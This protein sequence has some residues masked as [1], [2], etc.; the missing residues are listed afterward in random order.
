MTLAASCYKDGTDFIDKAQ[1]VTI[2]PVAADFDA[3]GT[4][5]GSECFTSTVFISEGNS[6][7]SDSWTAEVDKDW[8]RVE[9]TT[10][11]Y[12]YTDDNGKVY[13]YPED[14]INIFVDANKA[15][16]RYFNLTI[17]T[18]SGYKEVIPF[19]QKGALA[20]AEVKSETTELSFL[21]KG[22]TKVVEYTSNMGNKYEYKAV[23]E[24]ETKEWISFVDKGVGKVEV[25]A[26]PWSDKE[27]SRK[28][29]VQI[30]VGTDAT[31]KAVLE[32]PV[33]QNANYD[34]FYMYGGAVD[35]K[36]IDASIEME[37]R[38]PT[39]YFCEAYVTSTKDGKN[40]ILINK[41]GRTLAYPCYALAANGSIVELANA[42]AEVPQGP[43]IDINGM[44][45]IT[46]IWNDM[47]WTM[48]NVQVANAMPLDEL[49]NYPTKAYA[50]PSGETKT[51]MT[52]CLHWNGGSGVGAMKLGSM[53]ASAS[54]PAND[55]FGNVYPSD[56]SSAQTFDC[57]ESGGQVKGEEAISN[58]YG[59]I[60][61]WDEV[62]LG[63]PMA[64][65]SVSFSNTAWPE[66][67]CEG[68]TF[69]DAVGREFTMPAGI[70]GFTGDDAAV[71]KATPTVYMQI[72]GICPYGWHVANL[73]DWRD[74][75][76]A[77]LK[78]CGKE[79]D[80]KGYATLTAG[81]ADV[82]ATLKGAEGWSAGTPA[83]NAY[84]DDFGF[85][86]YPLGRRLYK[87]GYANLGI[88][89]EIWVCHPGAK[90]DIDCITGE[91]V[92]KVWRLA[93]TTYNGTTKLN[94]T[95]DTGNATA[96]IRCVKNYK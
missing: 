15:Y 67:Y 76:Y 12:S 4:V 36:A 40:Q 79:G 10:V 89:S 83:R 9:K 60:Y 43:A 21:A 53:V 61:A 7:S 33:T 73:Q 35:G 8:A 41:N 88:N 47:T 27:N 24:G 64:G 5:D 56:R 82:A 57:T 86:I 90:G 3:D 93:A 13:D 30:I 37:R 94:G 48:S 62:L 68:K 65:M 42:S 23:Y 66:K 25:V 28:A 72:Q 52:T 71:E 75:F 58:K 18:E 59:R 14:G 17:T 1:R 51:W 6:K 29:K 80:Y 78:A 96:P 46:V 49:A 34:Y 26:A 81:N 69:T 38:N 74:L 44:K 31:S 87:S 50:T 85:N 2:S 22:E 92:Y 95:F 54:D 55:G 63:T 45:T 84:A 16:R 32:I 19:C 91:Q 77:A 20:D 39:V 70:D 11:V